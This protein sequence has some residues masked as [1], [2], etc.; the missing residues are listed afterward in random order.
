[1]RD[2]IVLLAILSTISGCSKL[3][4]R[5]D[6]DA[7]AATATAT[8]AEATATAT[9]SASA[10][11]SAPV[12]AKAT[13]SPA[14]PGAKPLAVPSPT[15]DRFGR[16]RDKDGPCPTGFTEQ[17]GVENHSYCAR[18][19]KTDADCHG[20]ACDDSMV[21]DGKVCSDA[22]SSPSSAKDAGAA[23][24]DAGSAK[25]PAS[26]CKA[27]EIDDG[28]SCLKTCEKDADCPA[29]QKCEQIRV[30]NPFGGTSAAFAC[31]KP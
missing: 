8:D 6:G 1:M 31:Q 22:P 4:S 12:T 20:H 28:S 29:K 7:G 24:K 25:T 18:N 5:G 19:C 30:P 10:A 13:A 3:L 26:K 2:C 9:P 17:P 14:K 15:T 23:G 11:M 27:N 21:G 16:N